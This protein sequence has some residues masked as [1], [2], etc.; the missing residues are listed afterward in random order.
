MNAPGEGNQGATV[1]LHL[2]T[3]CISFANGDYSAATA[4]LSRLL[5]LDPTNPAALAL[6]AEIAANREDPES[7]PRDSEFTRWFSAHGQA[8]NG[9]VNPLSGPQVAVPVQVSNSGAGGAINH[10]LQVTCGYQFGAALAMNGTVWTWGSGSHGELGN[11]TT[12]SSYAP[13]QVSGLTNVTAISA[14]YLRWRVAGC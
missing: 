14:G 7:Q 12:G 11:G 13:T 4:E 3:A 2:Q 8:G 1:R 10:P 5:E 9:T 6:K